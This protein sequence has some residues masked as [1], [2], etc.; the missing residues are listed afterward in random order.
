[1]FSSVSA[2]CQS[3]NPVPSFPVNQSFPDYK[4]GFG[5]Q[6]GVQSDRVDK[7]ALGWEEKSA[8][9]PHESQTGQSDLLIHIF[10]SWLFVF[11]WS[12]VTCI[13]GRSVRRMYT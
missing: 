7:S 6:Y 10:Q 2:S 1:M 9:A 4:K 12:L 5:G 13:L 11:V 3:V 8:V